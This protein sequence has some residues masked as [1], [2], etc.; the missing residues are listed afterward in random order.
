M[1]ISQCKQDTRPPTCIIHCIYISIKLTRITKSYLSYCFIKYVGVY[2]R[3]LHH[4]SYY[5][6]QNTYIDIPALTLPAPH[7]LDL[8]R[9]HPFFIA[10]TYQEA[11]LWPV[12]DKISIGI[13]GVGFRQIFGD[14]SHDIGHLQLGFISDVTYRP[15]LPRLNLPA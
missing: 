12:V 2:T 14:Q 6:M 10:S 13:Y 11:Q 4:V 8:C 9:V 7:G 15:I 1:M 3:T 5:E